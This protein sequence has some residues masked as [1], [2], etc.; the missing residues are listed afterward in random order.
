MAHVV[1]VLLPERVRPERVRPERVD[2]RVA[3]ERVTPERVTIAL[4]QCLY[5]LSV[6][7]PD[8]NIG[9][10]LTPLLPAASLTVARFGSHRRAARR[11]LLG[12]STAAQN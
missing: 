12:S 4:G 1:L 2:Q 10:L 9:P 8:A 5:L 3:P 6:F 7:S 11:Q